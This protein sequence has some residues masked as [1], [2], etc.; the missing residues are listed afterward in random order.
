MGGIVDAIFGGGNDAPAPPDP[1][2]VANAQGT[3]NIDA[4]RATTALNRADQFTPWGSLTWSQGGDKYNQSGYDNALKAWQDAGGTG[5]APTKESF[6]FAPDSWTSTVK[7]DPRVQ[8]LFDAN[9][10]TSLG[11][12][13]S[14][15][16][17]LGNVNTTLKNPITRPDAISLD[18]LK[19]STS[20]RFTD[21]DKPV[22]EAERLAAGGRDILAGQVNRLDAL[23]QTDFNYDRAPRMP[24]VRRIDSPLPQ[25]REV[26]S[27]LPQVREIDSPLPQVREV[28]SPLPSANNSVRQSVEDALYSRQASRLDPRWQQSEDRLQSSLAAQGITQGSEAYNRETANFARD[29]NDAYSNAILNAITGGGAEMQRQFGMDMAGR[30]Q[31]FAENNA[32]FG[33]ESTNRQ[34]LFNENNAAFGQGLQARQQLFNEN[35]TIF[36]QGLQA[37]QQLFNENNAAF[38]QGLQARQQGV[39]EANTLRAL[40]TQEAIA[41][42]NIVGNLDNAS[43][44]W[45][46]QQAAQEGAR[47]SSMVNQ[48]NLARTSGQDQLSNDIVIRNQLLNE[49][50]ALRTGAQAQTPQ[51]G[52]TNSGAQVGASP[53]AQS[54]YNSYQGDMANYQAGVGSNNA[55]LGGL[56]S[57]GS[58]AM[59]APAGTF[60]S[61]AAMF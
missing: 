28:D 40:P 17:S 21:I 38:G 6:G 48:F 61:L 43:R 57:L 19:N 47:D 54:V 8:A 35:N 59:M 5:T 18:A 36:G 15:D 14:I 42:A 32:A 11:L 39:G 22:T 29:R 25:V 16:S 31:E 37:R 1:Y 44:A 34:Q 52:N 60:A 9:L 12:Q 56:T 58:A 24:E 4:A 10:S 33:Q 53:I 45:V 49:L 20:Q 2:A 30:Q 41:T 51:F 3:A 55:M 46:G 50:N 23:Y 26:D 13:E 27:P 7:L